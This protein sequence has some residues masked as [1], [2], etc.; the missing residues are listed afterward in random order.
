MRDPER[1][2]DVAADHRS[3][4]KLGRLRSAAPDRGEEDGRTGGWHREEPVAAQEHPATGR[5]PGEPFAERGMDRR[6]LRP[7]PGDRHDRD[8]QSPVQP[9]QVEHVEP[10][11]HRTVQQDGVEPFESAGRPHEAEDL[12]RRVAAVDP[13]PTETDG[14]HAVR[15]GD[16]DGRER[17][18]AVAATEGPVVD[19][20][21]ADVQLR[22]SRPQ[23]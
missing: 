13:Y 9:V 11:Y 20:D 15:G 5:V 21:H 10:S 17:S 14:L 6:E 18:P 19:A 22:E 4:E 16:G 8:P 3:A 7:V 1:F 12:G 23:R 2:G